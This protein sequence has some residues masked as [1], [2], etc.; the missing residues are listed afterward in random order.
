MG[1]WR[2]WSARFPLTVPGIGVVLAVLTISA[3]LQIATAA[4]P[5]LVYFH[6]ST[7]SVT[8]VRTDGQY[9][10]W[11]V[12]SPSV[13]QDCADIMVSTLA[14]SEPEVLATVGGNGYYAVEDGMAV[15]SSLEAPCDAGSEPVSG[16]VTLFDIAGDASRPLSAA[17]APG[18]VALDLPYVAWV[19]YT[20]DDDGSSLAT[21]WALD[22]Q[23][24]TPPTAVYTFER[25][26]QDVL[27]LF[28]VNDTVYWTI[29][30]RF[31]DS[32]ET[33]IAQIGDDAS[34][35]RSLHDTTEV[36]I[37]GNV[38]VTVTEGRPLLYDL[39]SAEVRWLADSGSDV[40]TD[41]RYVYWSEP[42]ESTLTIVG[43]DLETNARFTLWEVRGTADTAAGLVGNISAGADAVVWTH[44]GFD[45]YLSAIYAM[46]LTVALPSAAQPAPGMTSPDWTYYPESGH[47][48]AN[49]FR[50]FWTDNGGLPVF[51]YPLTEEFDY[52][53]PETGNAHAAQM[54]ERQ[55]FE[56][57][58]ENIGT[59][60]AV[61]LGRL[62]ETIL[63]DQ[64]R[65]WETFEKADP[66]ADHYFDATGHAI[67][68]EF[69]GYWSSH[70]LDL[71]HS[72]VSFDESLALFGY[73]L[74]EPM[75]ETNADGDT[76]L[77]QYFE[78]AVFEY[79]PDNPEPS[80]V[81][82]RRLGAELMDSW[83]W[84]TSG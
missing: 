57:H 84:A 73:P 5:D 12:R 3:P 54:T 8:D 21:I 9:A 53:S 58:P 56:W 76:V 33:G 39:S 41:G 62:G 17:A 59:P 26:A 77:T 4:D 29:G 47:Y 55:R 32:A 49:D 52:L 66:S 61:L 70:G 19:A 37:T 13:H 44:Y 22:T 82:L 38:M 31:S 64:G 67:T 72:G 35:F 65:D 42:T 10:L 51:G 1:T 69:Y 6:E 60:Y 25:D 68:P 46:S 81:L 30:E 48:L 20:D 34:F 40:A 27:E 71:G 45:S 78:R 14:Q 11:R 83:E 75:M 7:D 28:L 63:H 2:S 43:L 74:S 16:G 18:L 36:A 24:D 80:Q 79:H 23:Q 15:V 50:D